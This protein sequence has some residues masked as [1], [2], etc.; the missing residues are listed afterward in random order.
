MV[1]P[2]LEGWEIKQQFLSL[3]DWSPFSN[4]N[5]LNESPGGLLEIKILTLYNLVDSSESGETP[6]STFLTPP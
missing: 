5:F 2:Q 1:G 3:P 4:Q 6:D